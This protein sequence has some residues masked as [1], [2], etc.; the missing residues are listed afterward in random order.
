[1]ISFR[2]P[3][4]HFNPRSREGS[5][6]QLLSHLFRQ[7][8]FNPRS[9]EGSDDVF[10]DLS[11]LFCKFQSTL[12]R[13]ERLTPPLYVYYSI[14]I[15]IHAPAKGATQ[16]HWRI[17]RLFAISIHA[18]AKGA[19]SLTTWSTATLQI[20]IHAPAK[21]ATLSYMFSYRLGKHFNPRSREGSDKFGKLLGDV[22][23]EI[24]IHAPA[25]GA[26]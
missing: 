17:V 12:P 1:M 23:G 3:T 2:I 16:N 19:T 4:T 11:V 26:T 13:R 15:S 22:F 14:T 8:Y 18:P 9:R 21:G 25:K 20:S 10:N 7:L 6:D 5:D 24:S